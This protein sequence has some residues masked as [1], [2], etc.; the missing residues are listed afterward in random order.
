MLLTLYD[1]RFFI[2]M[3]HKKVYDWQVMA[4]VGEFIAYHDLTKCSAVVYFE[5]LKIL[6]SSLAY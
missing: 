1:I 3:I 2:Y 6:V 4:D 5:K